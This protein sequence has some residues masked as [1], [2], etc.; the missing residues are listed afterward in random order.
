MRSFILVAVLL[1]CAASPVTSQ[2]LFTY[3]QHAVSKNEFVAA[4]NKNPDTTGDKQQQLQEYLNLYINFRLKLQAAYDE[5]ADKRPEV[6]ADV[7][8]FKA[9]IADNFIN[10]AANVN[11]L[12]HEAF[13]RSQKDI[14]L[15]QIF[16]PFAGGDT[17]RAFTAIN[18]AAA[19][20]A[21]GK[22]FDEVAA[23]YTPGAQQ[24]QTDGV[25]GYVTVFT[26]PYAIENLVYNLKAGSYSAVYKSPA[27]YHLFKNKSERAALG[28]RSIQQLLFPF[29]PGASPAE[30]AVLSGTADSVYQLLVNG[31]SFASLFS[32]Y[33]HTNDPQGSGVMQVKVGDY[34]PAFEEKVFSIKNIGDVSQPFKTAYGYN[35]I[36]LVEKEPVPASENDVAYLA[37]LQAQLQNDGRMAAARHAVIQKWLPRMG[38]KA[39]SVNKSNLWLYTDSALASAGPPAAYRGIQPETVLFAFAKQKH[40][41]KDWI[42]YLQEKQV[43]GG[44][45][46]QREMDAYIHAAAENYLKMHI[47]DFD[48]S[49]AAQIR[50]FHEANMLFYIM[51]KNVWGK[52][53]SD[54]AGQQ[55]FYE[56]FGAKYTWQKS[57]AALVVSARSRERLDS[58]AA[59]LKVRPFEWRRLLSSS[60]DV[61]VDSSR[62]EEGQFPVKAAVV[63]EKGFQTKPEINDT[64]DAFTLVHVLEV[65]GEPG[66]KSF[67]EARGAVINDYQQQL[68]NTWLENL[69]QQY[70]IKLNSSVFKSIQP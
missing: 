1:G 23:A 52:A 28:T 13:Q 60:G 7:E 20:L 12:L 22:S 42:E 68:E 5:G 45:N 19:E 8:L 11:Q 31:A 65:Y 18:K 69:K 24:Q 41:V 57:A 63:L 30:E 29:P 44:L 64:G 2:T 37:R 32:V 6:M 34:A 62:F 48:S 40:N 26:L 27:G 35:I 51:D 9:Q 39:S 15:Q 58:I 49:A 59:E 17:S 38:Y 21:A 3:G 33:G 55:V 70:P 43:A 16:V 56:K 46:H 4:F 14:L 61:Y 47:A 10:R 36:K 25:V 50:E 66:K 53:A 54:S 67:E